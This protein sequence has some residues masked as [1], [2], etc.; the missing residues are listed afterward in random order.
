MRIGFIVALEVLKFFMPMISRDFSKLYLWCIEKI[1]NLKR[2]S[3]CMIA[4]SKGFR[5]NLFLSCIK[6]TC[7]GKNSIQN[8]LTLHIFDRLHVATTSKN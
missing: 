2:I 1:E 3:S 4:I 6:E 7:D 5:F 8:R